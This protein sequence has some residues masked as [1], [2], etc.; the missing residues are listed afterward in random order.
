VV[1]TTT[2]IFEPEDTPGGRLAGY[3][4][5]RGPDPPRLPIGLYVE[6]PWVVYRFYDHAGDLLY[7]GMTKHLERRIEEHS[8]SQR[9]WGDVSQ[10]ACEEVATR[11]DAWELEARRIDELRPIHNGPFRPRPTPAELLA[12]ARDRL[13]DSVASLDRQITQVRDRAAA[14][15]ERLE[16]RRKGEQRVFEATVSNLEWDAK[17]TLRFEEAKASGS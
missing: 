17:R 2:P 9:W 6:R 1:S 14:E 11:K 8:K 15:I 13:R 12:E 16:Q 5:G 4:D 10:V 7:V 3:D